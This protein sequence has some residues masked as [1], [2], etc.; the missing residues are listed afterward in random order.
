MKVLTDAAAQSPWLKIIVT[1]RTEV[2]IQHFFDTLAQPS[3][4]P[5]DLATDH[6]DSADLRTFA[7]S[8]FDLVISDW[9]LPPVA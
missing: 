2:D 5:Y 6:D 9:H 7:R 3:Y 4:I 1:N 8:Q